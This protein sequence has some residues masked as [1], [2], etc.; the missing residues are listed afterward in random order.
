V[1]LGLFAAA[2]C[3]PSDS[4]ES[5]SGASSDES[6]DDA[7][8]DESDD[9]APGSLTTLGKADDDDDGADDDD[10]GAD[11]DDDDDDD[12]SDVPLPGGIDACEQETF[13]DIVVEYCEAVTC[14]QGVDDCV[15]RYLYLAGDA[16]AGACNA[17]FVGLLTCVAQDGAVCI[18]DEDEACGAEVGLLNYCCYGCV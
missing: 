17:E 12:G 16:C 5:D 8:D 14:E 11:D 3:D 7:S 15:L 18:Y 4:V 10:D 6:S 9:E 1:F 13:Q 2:G